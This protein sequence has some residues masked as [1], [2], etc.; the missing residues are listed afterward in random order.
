[1][2]SRVNVKR[3][4]V[5]PNR[6]RMISSRFGD[7]EMTAADESVNAPPNPSIVWYCVAGSTSITESAGVG[8][9]NVASDAPSLLVSPVDVATV[10]RPLA[11]LAPGAH[12]KVT[13]ELPGSE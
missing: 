2:G 10:K 9:P 4:P 12:L 13:I 8:A 6:L 5:L 1:M 7:A 3:A 11:T